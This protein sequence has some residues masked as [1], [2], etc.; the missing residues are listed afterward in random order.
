[1][2]F[3]ID[4]FRTNGLKHGGARPNLFEIEITFP[5]LSFNNN[6]AKYQAKS[7]FLPATITTSTNI[8]YLGR[9]FKEP[10]E[11]TYPQWTVTFVNDENFKLR[12]DLE[13]WLDYTTGSNKIGMTYVTN[14]SKTFDGAE[15]G[16]SVVTATTKDYVGSAKAIQYSKNGNAIKAYNF[17]DIYPV[18]LTDIALSWDS[19]NQVEE[20]SCTFDY[21]YFET[22]YD[23]VNPT[24]S[25]N[26]NSGSGYYTNNL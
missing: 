1:M 2:G 24:E 13:K 12:N 7:S 20:Y 14:Y 16:E 8:N 23:T 22:S 6:Y 10:G 15:L 5:F 21:Q 18:T 9:N 11:R 19:T 17:V 3:S 25:I 26:Y 4:D